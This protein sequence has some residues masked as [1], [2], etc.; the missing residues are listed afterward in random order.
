MNDTLELA[1]AHGTTDDFGRAA[2]VI[3]KVA[4]ANTN[5]EALAAILAY[6]RDIR[7]ELLRDDAGAS[8]D[9]AAVRLL[10]SILTDSNVSHLAIRIN[11]AL[12]FMDAYLDG[13]S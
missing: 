8:I 12:E 3:G 2:D 1:A 6:R 13:C 9:T 7:L 10:R 5:G 11:N 4:A